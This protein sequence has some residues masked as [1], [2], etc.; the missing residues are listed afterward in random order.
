MQLSISINCVSFLVL[1]DENKNCSQQSPPDQVFFFFC[2]W[3]RE[4]DERVS[5][6][7]SVFFF[8]MRSSGLRGRVTNKV[9]LDVHKDVRS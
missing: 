6:G 8:V 5:K 1:R 2:S 3:S 9:G 4:E 7:E